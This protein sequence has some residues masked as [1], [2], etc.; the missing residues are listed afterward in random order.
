[1]VFIALPSQDTE[2]AAARLRLN[3]KRGDVDKPVPYPLIDWVEPPLQAGCFE[4][5]KNGRRLAVPPLPLGEGPSSMGGGLNTCIAA[6]T[7]PAATPLATESPV[8][9]CVRPARALA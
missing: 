9:A 2:R 7:P 5:V 3:P 8:P 6:D 4:S 1:L